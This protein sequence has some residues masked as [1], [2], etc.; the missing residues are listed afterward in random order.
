MPDLFYRDPKE[1]ERERA[2]NEA[3]VIEIVIL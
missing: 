3:E 1:V 2:A